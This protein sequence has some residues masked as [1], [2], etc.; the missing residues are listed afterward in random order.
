MK[1][2]KNKNNMVVIEDNDNY[3]LFSYTTLIAKICNIIN[4]DSY[5]ICLT[6]SWNYSRTTLKHLYNFI[7]LYSTQRDNTNNTI[8][9]MLDKTNNKK[10]YIQK[11]INDKNIT[12]IDYNYYI[13]K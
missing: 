13:N 10:E 3:Y 1:M 8:A 2:L 12:I 9:Y 4:N 5:G 11:L 6:N 7:G